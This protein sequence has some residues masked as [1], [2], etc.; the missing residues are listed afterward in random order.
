MLHPVLDLDQIPMSTESSAYWK[1]I[2]PQN[3]TDI[4]ASFWFA[5][6]PSYDDESGWFKRTLQ[7]QY[8]TSHKASVARE[9]KDSLKY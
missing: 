5:I 7:G 1:S 8:F 6:F 2:S 9:K 4:D 3:S